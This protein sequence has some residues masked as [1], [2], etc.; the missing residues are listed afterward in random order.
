[1]EKLLQLT[2]N[3]IPVVHDFIF[4]FNSQ[5]AVTCKQLVGCLAYILL[6]ISDE[7]LLLIKKNVAVNVKCIK[8]HWMGLDN[9]EK[10]K[11]YKK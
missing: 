1:M 2:K 5:L 3:E 11:R 6:T 8:R 9:K 7:A 10:K 4:I